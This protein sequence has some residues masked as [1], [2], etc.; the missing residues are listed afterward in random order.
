[1][2]DGFRIGGIAVDGDV[3]SSLRFFLAER[4]KNLCANLI[5]ADAVRN[6]FRFDFGEFTGADFLDLCNAFAFGFDG[7]QSSGGN[8]G[9][10]DARFNGSRSGIVGADCLGGLFFIRHGVFSSV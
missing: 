3:R 8:V 2:I 10:R 4:G 5:N 1:M 9:L 7:G 6:G